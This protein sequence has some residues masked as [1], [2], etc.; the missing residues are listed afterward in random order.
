MGAAGPS[1]IAL[2][3]D[4]V[5][6]GARRRWHFQRLNPMRLLRWLRLRQLHF[7]SRG[8]AFC[9]SPGSVMNAEFLYGRCAKTLSIELFQIVRKVRFA[10]SQCVLYA[11]AIC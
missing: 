6:A 1:K 5:D 3:F 8:G 4:Y 11:A 10:N 9:T 7:D 2:D